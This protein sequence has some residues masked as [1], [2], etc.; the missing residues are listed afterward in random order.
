MFLIFA[1]AATFEQGLFANH[2]GTQITSKVVNITVDQFTIDD[3][4]KLRGRRRDSPVVSGGIG[5]VI[6][7]VGIITQ[8][9]YTTILLDVDLVGYHSDE[10]LTQTTQTQVRVHS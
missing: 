4:Q 3:I 7:D 8:N 2:F 9:S 6:V 10:R 1:A 5:R